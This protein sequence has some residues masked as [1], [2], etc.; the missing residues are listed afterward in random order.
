[1]T[2]GE[3]GRWEGKGTKRK[4]EERRRECIEK[5]KQNGRTKGEE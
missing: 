3:G 1:V 5:E 4:G 2:K